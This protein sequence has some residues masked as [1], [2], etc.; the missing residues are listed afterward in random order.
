MR[1][2]KPKALSKSL[3]MLRQNRFSGA[4]ILGTGGDEVIQILLDMM[5]AKA[6]YTTI[7]RAMHIH[8]TVAEFLPT[9]LSNL[10]PFT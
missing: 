2:E 5:Y 8:P 7:Q 4:A 3:L 10:Q 1:R 6:P 9:V